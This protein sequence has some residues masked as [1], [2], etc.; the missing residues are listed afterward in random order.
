MGRTT[1]T[2]GAKMNQP[3]AYVEIPAEFPYPEVKRGKVRHVFDLGDNKLLICSSDRISAYDVV[4]LNG[5]PFK[6][7]VLNTISAWW[8]KRTNRVW[9]NHFITDDVDEY[10]EDLHSF[11]PILQGRSMIVSRHTPLPVEFVVR[12]VLVRAGSAWKEYEASGTICGEKMPADLQPDVWLSEPIITPATKAEGGHDI[13]ISRNR[14]RE[15]I[16]EERANRIF[17]RALALYRFQRV[18]LQHHGIDFLDTKYEAG[19]DEINIDEIGTPDSSRYRPDYSKQP[20]RDWLDSIGFDRQTPLEIPPEIV[21]QTSLLYRKGLY[22]ITK[23]S[24]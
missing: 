11:R 23:I 15:M 12:G 24:L 10:P 3:V 1:R 8:F 6:G 14:V 9:P 17:E 18:I 20:F 7:V 13:N 2:G 21:E 22:Q 19:E 5:I 16:G 4:M